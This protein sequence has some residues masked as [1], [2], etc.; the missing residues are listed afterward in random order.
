V[1]GCALGTSGESEKGLPQIAQGVVL[2]Q[3]LSRKWINGPTQQAF[4]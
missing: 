2:I 4:I 3:L 1:N